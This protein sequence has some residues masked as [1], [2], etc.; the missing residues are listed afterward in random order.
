MPYLQPLIA[1]ADGP[2]FR[3][4]S[5]QVWNASSAIGGILLT[6]QVQLHVVNWLNFSSNASATVGVLPASNVAPVMLPLGPTNLVI[7]SG[8][9]L[10]V[11]VDLNPAQP[12]QCPGAPQAIFNSLELRWDYR[13]LIEFMGN[14][15]GNWETLEQASAANPALTDL[16]TDLNGPATLQFAAFALPYGTL[17]ELRATVAY[18]NAPAGTST[19]EVVFNIVVN[20]R[21]APTAVLIGPDQ[22]SLNCTFS[23]D[24]SASHD[25][26]HNAADGELILIYSWACSPAAVCGSVANNAAG[27]LLAVPGGSLPPGSYNFSV[28]VARQ[29]ETTFSPAAMWTVTMSTAA[30]SETGL[31]VV[32]PWPANYHVTVNAPMLNLSAIVWGGSTGVCGLPANGSW[33]WALVESLA[34]QRVLEVLG[35]TT[36]LSGESNY[37]LQLSHQPVGLLPGYSYAYALLESNTP[38]ELAQLLNVVSRPI[39]LEAARQAGYNVAVSNAFIIDGAPAGGALNVVPASGY[40]VITRFSAMMPDWS[41]EDPLGLKYKFYRFPATTDIDNL[42]WDNYGSANS[43]KQNGGVVLQSWSTLSEVTGIVLSGGNYKVVGRVMDSLGATA[44]VYFNGP[45]VQENYLT[46]PT[47]E[48]V[49]NLAMESYNTNEFFQTVD[50]V[51]E[52]PIFQGENISALTELLVS[53]FEETANSLDGSEGTARAGDMVAN[54]LGDTSVAEPDVPQLVRVATV[55]HGAVVQVSGLNGLSEEQGQDVLGGVSAISTAFSSPGSSATLSAADGSAMSSQLETLTSSLGAAVLRATE[56]GQIVS[57]SATQADGTGVAFTGQRVALPDAGQTLDLGALSVPAGAFTTGARRLTSSCGTGRVQQTQWI[58]RNIYYWATA[59]Q[60]VVN[61]DANLVAVEV[62][63]CGSRLS[64]PLAAPISITLPAPVSGSGTPICVRFDTTTSAWVA[65][66]TVSGTDGNVTC[67]SYQSFG[68]Y[69]AILHTTTTTGTIIESTTTTGIVSTLPQGADNS[70]TT[71]SVPA[72]PDWFPGEGPG[73]QARGAGFWAIIILVSL[74]GCAVFTF[75]CVRVL[76]RAQKRTKEQARRPKPKITADVAVQDFTDI[77]DL[78]PE[79]EPGFV[80][81][82][83]HASGTAFRPRDVGYGFEEPETGFDDDVYDDLPVYQPNI[84]ATPLAHVPQDVAERRQTSMLASDLFDDG[85]EDDYFDEPPEQP[86]DSFQAVAHRPAPAIAAIEQWG[87]QTEEYFVEP[88]SDEANFD[89]PRRS[90][91]LMQST[92]VV[93][94]DEEYGDYGLEQ[95]NSSLMPTAERDESFF[96]P[97]LEDEEDWEDSFSMAGRNRSRPTSRARVP[98]ST[99][100]SSAPGRP[101]AGQ[102]DQ[103]QWPSSVRSGLSGRTMQF[104]SPMGG[105]LSEEDMYAD[106]GMQDASGVRRPFADFSSG[107]V[108]FSGTETGEDSPTGGTFDILRDSDFEVPQ[109]PTSMSPTTYRPY[110]RERSPE[111]SPQGRAPPWAPPVGPT[112]SAEQAFSEQF[113]ELQLPKWEDAEEDERPNT[114]VGGFVCHG[115]VPHLDDS[116][117]DINNGSGNYPGN[118]AQAEYPGNYTPSAGGYAVNY[119]PSAVGGYPG[120]S[121]AAGGYPPISP[122]SRVRLL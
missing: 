20:A 44:T 16:A 43:W 79:P 35:T 67:Q 70:S 32:A 37:T 63:Q 103:F 61:S 68:T 104:R 48:E 13:F 42:D 2:Q 75:V 111:P 119:T 26:S 30:G 24:A 52:S 110:V 118:Y 10:M 83:P 99:A 22:A 7:D 96:P 102:G 27:P 112:I 69:A 17:H 121:P 34:S 58:R 64:S 108:M 76:L 71:S 81:E 90:L 8:D 73:A 50:A 1:S 21:P 115:N 23:L 122:T 9:E 11:G 51:A 49:L 116:S 39:S 89:Q 74:L 5:G 46:V 40:A 47:V 38:E 19:T 25:P 86:Q 107:P 91:S 15:I 4:T 77:L 106:A 55:L 33:T 97:A 60:Y 41:D 114:P 36:Q 120:Y 45:T 78:P 62:L 94:D 98:W 117:G 84:T 100:S 93:F 82:Q 57:V 3:L 54:L 66:D 14:F 95:L 87:V 109:P 101:Y 80:F 65:E 29:G 56:L 105:G 53:S 12:T 59:G 92:E 72:L 6:L 31:A 28:A 85:E 113:P 88:D 18:A